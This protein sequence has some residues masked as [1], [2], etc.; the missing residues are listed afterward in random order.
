MRFKIVIPTMKTD[1]EYRNSHFF[2]CINKLKNDNVE[3]HGVAIQVFTENRRGLS[4]LYQ[5][6]L[7]DN[8][9]FDYVVF[10]HDDLEIHDQFFFEKLIKAHEQYNIVGLAGATSQDYSNIIMPSGQELPL[11]W[12]LRKTKPEH[13]RG[14][15]AHTIPEGLNG[16]EFSHINSAY[17]G[18]TPCKVAVIDGLFM[19]FKVR[20]LE[21]KDEVFDRDFTF[22]H[23]DMGMA[24]R[25]NR[26]NLTMGVYPI[27]CIHHGLGEYASDKTWHIMAEK[28]KQK[29][30][31]YKIEV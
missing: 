3:N 12:H 28:F 26:M 1:E 20:S 30:G 23:Y 7:N 15:V 18:P 31:N 19:S 22:H 14:I 8:K 4:E 10:I 2:E 13:G 24:V 27:F 17:F 11:V 6:C 9:T 29:Y 5:E 21:E 16:C 25:A